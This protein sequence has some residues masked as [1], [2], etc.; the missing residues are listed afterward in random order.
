V[1]RRDYWVIGR[2]RGSV[3]P[4]LVTQFIISFL[5]GHNLAALGAVVWVSEIF[6]LVAEFIALTVALAVAYAVGAHLMTVLQGRWKARS[7]RRNESAA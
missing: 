3:L 1:A 2:N 6:P 7:A 4:I 5:L